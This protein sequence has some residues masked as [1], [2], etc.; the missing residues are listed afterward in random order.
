[1]CKYYKAFYRL[2]HEMWSRNIRAMCLEGARLEAHN[3]AAKFNAEVV[4][5]V[6][7]N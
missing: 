2:G 7:L 6:E 3:I 5:V 4:E 1:M